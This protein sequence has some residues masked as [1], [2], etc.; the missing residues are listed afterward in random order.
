MSI[1]PTPCGAS[2]GSRNE[3]AMMPRKTDRI[4]KSNSQCPV[5]APPCATTMTPG[6]SGSL[7]DTM[8]D[9]THWGLSDPNGFLIN[10]LLFDRHLRGPRVVRRRCYARFPWANIDERERR[11]SFTDRSK[12]KGLRS[13]CSSHGCDTCL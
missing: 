12:M 11:L 10:V 1:R 6:K 5:N 4:A 8:C 2:C 13:A 7:A 9:R 3:Y